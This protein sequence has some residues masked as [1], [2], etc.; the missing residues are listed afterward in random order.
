MD[1]MDNIYRLNVCVQFYRIAIY[2]DKIDNIDKIDNNK[3][4]PII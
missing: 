3:T 1:K 4:K 2:V